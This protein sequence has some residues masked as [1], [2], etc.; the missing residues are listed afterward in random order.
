VSIVFSCFSFRK[1]LTDGNEQI[2]FETFPFN[3]FCMKKMNNNILD[4]LCT[5]NHSQLSAIIQQS[6]Q[7]KITEMAIQAY[8]D[9]PTQSDDKELTIYFEEKYQKVRKQIVLKGLN[10]RTEP[11]FWCTVCSNFT[12][13]CKCDERQWKNIFCTHCWNS[14]DP[15]VLGSITNH[16]DCYLTWY[17]NK[18]LHDALKEFKNSDGRVIHKCDCSECNDNDFKNKINYLTSNVKRSVRLMRLTMKSIAF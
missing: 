16:N 4:C 17:H 8:N 3:Y 7:R 5:F 18:P 9:F 10:P 2:L 6:P 1:Q 13:K 11:L 12:T 14:L 15:I